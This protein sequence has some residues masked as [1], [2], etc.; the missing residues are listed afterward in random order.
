[1]TSKFVFNEYIIE[2]D[3]DVFVAFETMN[4]RGKS[5]STLELLKNRLI[6]LV[7]LYDS[8]LEAADVN[9]LR[10]LIN[11]AWQEIYYQLGRNKEHP[12]NDDD[13]LKAHWI[14][15]F[16]YTRKRSNDFKINLLEIE[17]SPRRIF[18]Q[19]GS[20]NLPI[21][22]EE[23]R[24][25]EDPEDDQEDDQND[26]SFTNTNRLTPNE[27][28]DYVLSLKESAGCWF[29]TWYPQSTKNLRPDEISAL[30]ALNRLGFTY[31]R[32][33]AMSILKNIGDSQERVNLFKSIERFIFLTFRLSQYRSNY[34]DSLFY[35]AARELDS[36]KIE[37]KDKKIEPKDIVQMLNDSMKDIF[38]E[39]NL[40]KTK[41]FES[42]LEK[43]F[44]KK[45][46]YYKWH[47]LHYFLYEYELYLY[48]Q[49]K[50]KAPSSWDVLKKTIK[51]K[52]SIE[53]IYPQTPQHEYWVEKFKD[54]PE[55]LKSNYQGSIGNL[56]L[57]SSAI[58]S[59]YQNDSFDEKKN[60]RINENQTLR[61]GYLKGSHSEI[62]VSQNANWTPVEI[63]K[64]GLDLIDFMQLRW[65]IKFD[66]DDEKNKA[67]AKRL[68]FL[69]PLDD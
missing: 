66:N 18:S 58:N 57:L 16:K 17:F 53:H 19:T 69:P 27:I 12:L 49:N 63:L 6:Y 44:E 4:N 52:I 46:G 14:M 29:N 61:I 41:Y 28:R 20:E 68:L 59:S 51:D 42:F 23:E 34:Q 2:S 1:L 30:E 15:Y 33:L 38:D 11:G 35:N 65:D 8:E 56:L 32:P 3:F 60:D 55:E 36:K 13:F 50:R 37:P 24:D 64:R 67:I 7:T 54:I 10:S 47:G 62:K 48:K 26:E 5:L 22:P 39:N 25:H 43:R 21:Q 40:F 31:F 45:I 9:S